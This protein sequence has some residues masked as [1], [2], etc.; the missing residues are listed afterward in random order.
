[1]PE[2]PS[3]ATDKP[4]IITWLPQG[5]VRAVVQIVHGMA[6][7]I[8]RYSG[9]AH[10]LTAHGYAVAGHNHRGHGPEAGALGSFGDR[11][12]WENVLRDTRAVHEGL[13]AHFP[14]KKQILLGHSMGSFVARE[15]LLRWGSGLDA[16]VLSGT[17]WHPRA[18]CTAGLLA[19]TL[20]GVLGGWGKPAALVDNMAFSG[21]N[22]PFAPARTPFDWLSRDEKE[23]DKYVSDPLCGFVFTARAYRDLFGGLHALSSLKRLADMPKRLPVLFISGENDPVGGM[24]KGVREVARQFTA[25]GMAHVA[26]KLYPGARH[27][28]FNEI[29][30]DEVAA[31]LVEWLDGMAGDAEELGVRS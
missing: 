18:L 24:G 10:A 11:D 6:E 30:R 12:G 20:C 14:G 9:I 1:M 22:K 15:Y 4:P 5:E 7:H 8:D 3:L 16:C 17:G 19:A 28:L 31:D 27:E 21:N 25:A 2:N 26:V 23:V 29:N 13:R